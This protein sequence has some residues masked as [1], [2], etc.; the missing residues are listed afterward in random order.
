MLSINRLYF[1]VFKPQKIDEENNF[2]K[3]SL[4]LNSEG[5]FIFY[6]GIKLNTN[7]RKRDTTLAKHSVYFLELKGKKGMTA[8][9]SGAI[10]GPF[11]HNVGV[12]KSPVAEPISMSTPQ[13]N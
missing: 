7:K 9:Q 6:Y 8:F 10:K 1:Y 11:S 12:Q 5:Q 2:G 13:M 3:K 4:A